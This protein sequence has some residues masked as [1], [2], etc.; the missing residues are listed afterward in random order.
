MKKSV[1]HERY[2][3]YK[4]CGHTI[5]TRTQV[6]DSLGISPNRV[7]ELVKLGALEPVSVDPLLYSLEHCQGCY[8]VR[9][10]LAPS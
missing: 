10:R 4:R 3:F 8:R 7:S 1:L 6:A 2:E 9:V 5:V